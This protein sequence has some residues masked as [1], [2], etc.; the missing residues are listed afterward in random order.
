MLNVLITHK[1]GIHHHFD[2]FEFKLTKGLW[3]ETGHQQMALVP[4][5]VVHDG[6]IQVKIDNRLSRNWIWGHSAIFCGL[7][8]IKLNFH[9]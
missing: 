3:D 6:K 5:R 7:L 8:D 4:E 1:I 2:T 9:F